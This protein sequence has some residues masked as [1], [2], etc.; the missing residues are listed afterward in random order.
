MTPI[1]LDQGHRH[2]NTTPIKLDQGRR[3]QNTTLIKLDQGHRQLKTPPIKLD[4]RFP[5]VLN[6]KSK[7]FFNISLTNPRIGIVAAIP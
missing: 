2:Q 4:Q 7:Y 6:I 3:R 5:Y 1:K